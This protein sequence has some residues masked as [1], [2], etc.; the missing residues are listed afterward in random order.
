[1]SISSRHLPWGLLPLL[2]LGSSFPIQPHPRAAL[3]IWESTSPQPANPAIGRQNPDAKLSKPARISPGREL[4][5]TW[6]SPEMRGQTTWMHAVSF[7]TPAKHHRVPSLPLS[8][9]QTGRAGMSNGTGPEQQALDLPGPSARWRHFSGKAVLYCLCR[10]N[11]S[12]LH[13]TGLHPQ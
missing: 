4:P 5:G 6:G 12:P 9:L 3:L 10:A 7:Q 8:R 2:G 11:C 1:M 13:G